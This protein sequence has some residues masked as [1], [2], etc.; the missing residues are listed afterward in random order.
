LCPIFPDFREGGSEQ[1]REG[2][3][4][5]D[6]PPAHDVERSLFMLRFDSKGKSE[7]FGHSVEPEVSK[8]GVE[9]FESRQERLSRGCYELLT[10]RS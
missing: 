7:G 6:K 2:A 4:V 3:Q 8:I 10:W 9:R 5:S 1:T